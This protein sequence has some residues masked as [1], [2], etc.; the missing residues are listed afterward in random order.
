MRSLGNKQQEKYA[1]LRRLHLTAAISVRHAY[2]V[3]KPSKPSYLTL[4]AVTNEHHSVRGFDSC[5]CP[6]EGL[7]GW[8]VCDVLFYFLCFLS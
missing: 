7:V 8:C 6:G 1:K 2:Q 5:K 4:I 3:D